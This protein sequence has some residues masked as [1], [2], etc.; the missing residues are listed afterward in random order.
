MATHW[1]VLG[2][3]LLEHVRMELQPSYSYK[4]I[5]DNE[6]II[7]GSSGNRKAINSRALTRGEVGSRPIN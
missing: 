7:G 4:S 6:Y 3:Q 5:S 2:G 1:L